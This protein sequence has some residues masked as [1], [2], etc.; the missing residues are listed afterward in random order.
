M[1]KI[2]FMDIK[3]AELT[4]YAANAMLATKI[5]FINEI[6]N[7]ADIFGANIESIRKG[8]GSDKRIGYDFLYPGCGYGGSC[9][10]KDINALIYSAKE[11]SYKPELLTAV[12]NFNN[13]QKLVLCKKINKFFKNKL[14][15]KTIA[16]WGLAF[17]PNTNDVRFATSIVT[18]EYLLSK[19]VNVKAYDPIASV[20]D[21]LKSNNKKK[22]TEVKSANLALA[23]A[24]ALVICTE[25][26]EFWSVEPKLFLKKMNKPVIFDGRNIYDPKNMKDAE[27]KYFAIGRGL[28]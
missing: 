15:G 28:S 24:D 19:G 12:E 1:N 22:Y 23:D 25:W 21:K 4:K 18:I 7:I 8:I 16:V 17:K 27:I 11:K 26:K 6:A 20:K 3:S 5:S 10:P 13:K 2:Q 9:F 14:S